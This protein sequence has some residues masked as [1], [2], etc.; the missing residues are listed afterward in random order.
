[1]TVPDEK[2][3]EAIPYLARHTGVFAEPAGAAS[4]AGLLAARD[5]G[6]VDPGDRVV[7]MV[8]GTGLKDIPS[9][10]RAVTKPVAIAPRLEAVRERCKP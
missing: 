3:L 10:L 2:I 8:T 5:E 6:L 4:L 9:A 1:M 7:L